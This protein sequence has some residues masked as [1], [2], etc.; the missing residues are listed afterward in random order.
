[1][2]A[3]LPLPSEGCFRATARL[4]RKPFGAR[5]QNRT[6]AACKSLCACRT[7]TSTESS[8]PPG[9]LQGFSPRSPLHHHVLARDFPGSILGSRA[10]ALREIMQRRSKKRGGGAQDQRTWHRAR[11]APLEQ[12]GCTYSAF[13]FEALEGGSLT[14]PPILTTALH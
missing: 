1:M 9:L 6:T 14:R 11:T 10:R 8:A 13:T 2:P 12:T 5:P 3:T 7:C 4:S